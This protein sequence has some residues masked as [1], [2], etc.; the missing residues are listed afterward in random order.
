MVILL[1]SSWICFFL[2]RLTL[3]YPDSLLYYAVT[4][5]PDAPSLRLVAQSPSCQIQIGQR[6]E[7]K[8]GVGIFVQLTIADLGKTKHTLEHR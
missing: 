7:H 6:T 8:Q 5:I 3:Y 2:R 4:G 1:F